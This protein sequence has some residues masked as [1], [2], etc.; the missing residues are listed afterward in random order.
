MLWSL[1][2]HFSLSAIDDEARADQRIHLRAM[3]VFVTRETMNSYLAQFVFAIIASAGYWL[4]IPSVLVIGVLHV[5]VDQLVRHNLGLLS[6]GLRRGE[7]DARLLRRIERIF[8]GV[9]FVWAMA[10]WPLAEALDG[11]RL[12]LTVVSAAGLLVM[13]STT[14]HAPRVFRTTVVGFAL[15]VAVLLATISTIP[16]FV[17]AGAT[18]AFLVTATAV[19]AGTARQLLHMLQMQ[20]QRDK[21]IEGQVRTIAA[22]DI[23]RRAATH[24]AETDN[25]TGLPNRFLF[26]ARLDDLIS[27]HVPLSLTLLDVDLF[28]NINDALGHNIGDEVLKTVG[29]V[30]AT[31]A[32]P[33]GF[34][35]R[36]GGDEFALISIRESGAIRGEDI[37]SA[38]RTQIDA[39]RAVNLDL[40]MFSITA[41]SAQFPEDASAGSDLLAAA[42]IAQREAKKSLRGGHL[43]YS[44]SLSNTFRRETQIAHAIHE[45]IGSRELYLCFQPKIDL[46][47]GRVV[48]AEALSRFSSAGLLD[49]RLDEIFEVA[50]NRGLAT[51]LDELV[52]D[53]YR[54]ALVALRDQRGIVLP[55][56]V[57]LSG[58]IL[59][60]PERLLAKLDRLIA[61]GLPPALTRVEI[62]ENAIY[63]RGQKAV[64]QLL[65]EIVTRGFSLALDD[66]GT[67]SGSLQHLARLPVAEIKIDRSFV[68]GMRADRRNSA[69]IGG[70]IVIGRAMGV[71][72]VAEGVETDDEADQLK[73]MGAQYAQGFLWS[74][75]LPISQFVDF[76][77]LFGGCDGTDK[78]RRAENASK[79]GRQFAPLVR[80]A[81]TRH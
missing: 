5:L 30:L 36:L 23:A 58:A 40:P 55:T 45:A 74:K 52:L 50:E 14:C 21:A 34:A 18:G 79:R 60:T 22:L 19:G 35:A 81:A 15:G 54:E 68:S 48:G 43:D 9:G 44:T 61:E 57:N 27:A 64:V 28:K 62:T 56:S 6:G 8:Y 69:I 41:G 33:S 17:L 29:G 66:F 37:L 2:T 53:R 76:V 71:D 63:G 42:D 26:L 47:S 13:A 51:I 7:I 65:D 11:L 78:D 12:L 32:G 24:M 80:I 73:S 4:D 75:P 59:K 25:L 10:A 70:L 39:V 46:R 77:R 1:K 72:I 38:L 31:F 49:G 67:G 3:E 20:A 16:W